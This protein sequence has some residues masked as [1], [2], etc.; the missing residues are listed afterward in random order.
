MT[1][2]VNGVQHGGALAYKLKAAKA[3]K[4]QA[5]NDVFSQVRAID[6]QVAKQQ[7][8]TNTVLTGSTQL[9]ADNQRR[10]E[11]LKKQKEAEG[12]KLQNEITEIDRE[13]EKELKELNAMQKALEKQEK[14][15]DTSLDPKPRNIQQESWPSGLNIIGIF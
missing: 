11:E 10:Q 6:A 2:T 4:T 15:M 5:L 1:G 13:L 12:D 8:S 14:E 7:T 3:E 9:N